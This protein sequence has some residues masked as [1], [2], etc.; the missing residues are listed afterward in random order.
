MLTSSTSSP[1]TSVSDP[2]QKSFLDK[3][4]RTNPDSLSPLLVGNETV[5][6]ASM[7][8]DPIVA[9][10]SELFKLGK[11]LSKDELK[12]GKVSFRTSRIHNTLSIYGQY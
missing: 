2:P 11:M 3:L 9:H 4:A 7:Q 12:S 8:R 1:T 5:A 10:C 6:A